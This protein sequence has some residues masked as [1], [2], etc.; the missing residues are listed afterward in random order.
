MLGIQ[1]L[2]FSVVKFR[3]VCGRQAIVGMLQFSFQHADFAKSL[4]RLPPTFRAISRLRDAGVRC[5]Y[6]LRSLTASLAQKARTSDEGS[7]RAVRLTEEGTEIGK[8]VLAHVETVF[9]EVAS[10]TRTWII[11]SM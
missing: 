4:L 2:R 1:K 8:T 6:K 3:V 10:Q 11:R 7:A 9:Q 5:S